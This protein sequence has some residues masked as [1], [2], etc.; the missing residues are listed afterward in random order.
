MYTYGVGRVKCLRKAAGET[1]NG[2][3]QGTATVMNA[4]E[5]HPPADIRVWIVASQGWEPA[6]L[7]DEPPA[8]RPLF[9]G[10]ERLLTRAEARAFVAGFNAE[11]L[12][13]AG[14]RW[15]VARRVVP[16]EDEVCSPPVTWTCAERTSREEVDLT[17]GDEKTTI[18]PNNACVSAVG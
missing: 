3:R 2:L 5:S 13:C 10:V 12:A 9:P 16:R 15:A 4:I 14:R 17:S 1:G 8:S 18:L 7:F 6:T 11:M